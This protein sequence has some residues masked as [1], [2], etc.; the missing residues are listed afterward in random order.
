MDPTKQPIRLKYRGKEYTVKYHHDQ[1]PGFLDAEFSERPVNGFTDAYIKLEDGSTI[2]ATA[3]CA[4]E[5]QFNK[6]KGRI[7][8]TSKLVKLIEEMEKDSN[9]RSFCGC[10]HL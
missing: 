5:D 6:K 8:S 2:T 4:A 9:L 3:Y 10:S 7:I 1:T